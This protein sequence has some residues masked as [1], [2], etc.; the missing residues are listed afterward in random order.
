[1]WFLFHRKAQTKAVAGG[2]ELS[3]QCPTCERRTRFVEVE[4][5]KKYGVWF[6][7]VLND[8]ETAFR[9]TGCGEV[10]ELK[11]PDEQKAQLEAAAKA[12]SQMDRVE[13]MAAE[14]RRRD[15]SKVKIAAKIDDELAEL[16]RRMGK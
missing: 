15:A 13:E 10:Y 11:V 5:T 2:R 12:K 4:V 16:K 14:Q 9:C 6:V 8:R 7:D 1:M 3:E